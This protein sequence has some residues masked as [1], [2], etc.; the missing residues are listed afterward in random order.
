MLIHGNHFGFVK[1]ECWPVVRAYLAAPPSGSVENMY[2]D[3]SE[4]AQRVNQTMAERRA[5][6]LFLF[7]SPVISLAGCQ[8]KE[9]NCEEKTMSWRGNGR[10]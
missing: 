6:C 4:S 5:M 8:Q 3:K 1:E 10:D 9:V 2:V 7:R